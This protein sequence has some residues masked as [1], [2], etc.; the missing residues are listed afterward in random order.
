MG[1]D[2]GK[3]AQIASETSNAA[4]EHT[5]GEEKRKRKRRR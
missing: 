3:S 2:G 1:Q 5:L 4:C